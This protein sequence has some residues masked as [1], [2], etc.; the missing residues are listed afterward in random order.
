MSGTPHSTGR[1]AWKRILSQS[2]TS[3]EALPERV[4]VDRDLLREVAARYPMRINPSKIREDE[5]IGY[6][7]SIFLRHTNPP[8]T[9][10][11]KF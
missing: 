4:K 3:P 6:N 8:K 11:R 1:P 10:P 5:M 9:F 7:P 2:I